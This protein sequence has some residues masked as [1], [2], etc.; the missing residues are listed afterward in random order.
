MGVGRPTTTRRSTGWGWPA[1]NNSTFDGV[2]L[3]GRQQVDVRRGGGRPADNNSTFDG[4]GVGRG[5]VRPYSAC[6][7]H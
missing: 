7:D 5:G 4:V 3:A 2:G 6:R 1:D